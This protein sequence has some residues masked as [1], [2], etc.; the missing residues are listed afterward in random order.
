MLFSDLGQPELVG[1][2]DQFRKSGSDPTDCFEHIL[3]GLLAFFFHLRD[4]FNTKIRDVKVYFTTSVLLHDLFHHS[5]GNSPKARA[6]VPNKN[7]TIS[8]SLS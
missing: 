6:V 1:R 3:V 2:P 8:A 5:Y 4:I 7:R